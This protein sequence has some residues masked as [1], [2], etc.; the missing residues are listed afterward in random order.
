[1]FN[2]LSLAAQAPTGG[3]GSIYVALAV[4][5][6]VVLA[7]LWRKKRRMNTAGQAAAQAAPET[8]DAAPTSSQTPPPVQTAGCSTAADELELVGITERDAA[9]V[10]AVTANAIGKAPEQLRFH[11]IKEVKKK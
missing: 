11:S 1:M 6:L 2:F 4:L 10:M 7:A 8:A 5:V 9:I 3:D